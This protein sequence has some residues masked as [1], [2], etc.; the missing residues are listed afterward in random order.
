MA[1]TTP[2]L[3]NSH[4]TLINHHSR[5]IWKHAGAARWP[6]RCWGDTVDDENPWCTFE[7]TAPR[8]ARYTPRAHPAF[9]S[10]KEIVDAPRIPHV[11]RGRGVTT[12][13]PSESR[14]AAQMHVGSRC[15]SK[16]RLSFLP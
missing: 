1:A 14:N 6:H 10:V 9:T 7:D 16:V 3:E 8:D 11:W 15:A 4:S 12:R 2:R 13:M 5:L